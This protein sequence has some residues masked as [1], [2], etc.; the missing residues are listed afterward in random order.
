[1]VR[2]DPDLIISRIIDCRE[3][4]GDWD[5]FEALAAAQ[6]ILYRDLVQAQRDHRAFASQVRVETAIAE[7]VS[8][9][10]HILA[11]AGQA[12]QAHSSHPV[13]EELPAAGVAADPYQL[14][15]ARAEVGRRSRLV[16]TWSGWA[17]AAV[18]GLVAT[19]Q[20]NARQATSNAPR[21]TLLADRSSPEATIVA[22]LPGVP[23][24]GASSL[25]GMDASA[26]LESYLDQGRQDGRVVGEQPMRL[27][28]IEQLPDGAGYR[29][30]Y[31]RPIVESAVVSR[32]YSLQPG[33]ETNGTTAASL[34]LA[35][36]ERTRP[37][38]RPQFQ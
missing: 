2:N 36:V 11:R 4:V 17:A 28:A 22:G 15:S 25:V 33:D 24:L 6:P 32:P 31:E 14:A 8:A 13:H 30:V 27:L 38:R 18:V 3:T 16:A 29:V 5:A 19:A 21:G 34:R 20:F 35:P 9:P 37:A 1:M 12:S 7:R 10:V 23:A 26:A